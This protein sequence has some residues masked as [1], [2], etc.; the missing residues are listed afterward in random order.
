[1]A[2]VFCFQVFVNIIEVKSCFR[3][4]ATYGSFHYFRS[5]AGLRLHIIRLFFLHFNINK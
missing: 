2:T 1:M 4:I 3:V 5:F